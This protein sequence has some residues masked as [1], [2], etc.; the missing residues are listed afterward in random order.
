MGIEEDSDHPLESAPSLAILP[1]LPT[2]EQSVSNLRNV[3][4]DLPDSSPVQRE[5]STSKYVPPHLRETQAP[6]TSTATSEAN[7]RL[8]RLLSGH[9][10]KLSPANITVIL[11]QIEALYSQHPRASMTAALTSLIVERVAGS[12]DILGE[13]NILSFAALTASFYGRGISLRESVITACLERWDK[14]SDDLGKERNN[15]V[16]LWCRLYNLDVIGC[17]FI[18]GVIRELIES[19]GEEAMRE[20]DVEALL[21]VIKSAPISLWC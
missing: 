7:P 1:A 15:V 18:Y 12:Q 19:K 2:T 10:N 20:E 14:R 13:I 21:I 16:K 5:A 6:P 9:L 17:H 8:N 4:F 3:R 11:A